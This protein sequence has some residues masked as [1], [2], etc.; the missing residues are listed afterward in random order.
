M[1]LKSRC[2]SVHPVTVLLLSAFKFFLKISPGL[3]SLTSKMYPLK[4]GM[5]DIV[6]P[7]LSKQ[8]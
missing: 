6:L 3:G 1:S 8:Y 4:L 2:L 5:S 7:I